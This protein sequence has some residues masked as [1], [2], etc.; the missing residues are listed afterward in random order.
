MDPQFN[1]TQYLFSKFRKR[2]N[3]TKEFKTVVDIFKIEEEH[4]TVTISDITNKLNYSHL[5]TNL[6][7]NLHIIPGDLELIKFDFSDRGNELEL[8][9]LVTDEIIRKNYNYILIDSAP[10]YSFYTLATYIACDAFLMPV[11]PDYFSLLGTNLFDR[12]FASKKRTYKLENVCLGI[13]FTIV[14]GNT[15]IAWDVERKFRSKYSQLLFENKLQKRTSIQNG[16][17]NHEMMLDNSETRRNITLITKE[18][19]E[20]VEKLNEPEAKEK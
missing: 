8:K 1:A 17:K 13:I 11:K 4:S 14:E 6:S 7:D 20:R 3:E 9:N 19:I 15:N 12:A 18:F 2:Y 10:T 16:V 5:I